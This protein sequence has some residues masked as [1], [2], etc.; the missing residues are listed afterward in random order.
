MTRFICY[1]PI[2]ATG[3]YLLYYL[4]YCLNASDLKL[5]QLIWHNDEMMRLG[6]LAHTLF[7][8][9]CPGSFVLVSAQNT[10]YK[11][12][13]SFMPY[14]IDRLLS[15]CWW[16]TAL[17][18]LGLP[19]LGLNPRLQRS[20]PALYH[21][22]TQPFPMLGWN[23]D[24]LLLHSCSI[25][26]QQCTSAH[27]WVSSNANC[28]VANVKVKEIFPPKLHVHIPLQNI[29]NKYFRATSIWNK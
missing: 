20:R 29:W 7:I 23:P 6:S 9:E 28:G 2:T 22:T 16:K 17:K 12:P 3:T 19:T 21:K 13:S 18:I 5:S 14:A 1:W 26:C 25:L 8:Q 24:K 15:F 11:A 10:E 27:H 4:L